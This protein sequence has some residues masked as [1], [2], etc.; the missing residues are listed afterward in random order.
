[1]VIIYRFT[2]TS[3]RLLCRRQSNF[4]CEKP[5]DEPVHSHEVNSATEDGATCERRLVVGIGQAVCDLTS[6]AFRREPHGADRWL[7]RFRFFDIEW[8]KFTDGTDNI[9]IQV[10]PKNYIQEVTSS[11]QA[12]TT[13]T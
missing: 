5:K 8:G 13:M 2:T 1:M 7:E 9:K 11:S 3:Q 10:P 6:E 12:S 4:L